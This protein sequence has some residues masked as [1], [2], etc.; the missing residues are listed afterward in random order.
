MKKIAIIG[1]ARSGKNTFANLLQMEFKKKY[2]DSNIYQ[3]AFANSIKRIFSSYFPEADNNYLFGPSELR[4]NIIDSK[5]V[6]DNGI[7]ISY[8]DGIIAIG[9]MGRSLNANF[10]INKLN[11]EF[12]H[13]SFQSLNNLVLITD[14][15]RQNEFDYCKSNGYYIVNILRETQTS[16]HSTETDQE[17]FRQLSDLVIDNTLPLSNLEYQAE[18]IIN[19]NVC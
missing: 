3:L 12:N 14:V 9:E 10:W 2:V 18:R 8:R 1:K 16:N 7:P 13:I 6:N 4:S 5:Y 19:E 17:T 11:E 15:R